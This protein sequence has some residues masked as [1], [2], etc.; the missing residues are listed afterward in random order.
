MRVAVVGATGAVGRE[1]LKVL[2]ARNFPLSELRLY[3]S[4]RS[5]GVRLAFR[6]EEIPVEPL[7]EGPLP[8]DLV[9][10]SAGGGHLQGQG[11]GLG[12]GRGLGGGQ[13]QRL[14]LRALGA[15]GGA[16]GE[17]GEDL[18]APGDHR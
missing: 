18:P 8:V 9:L 4:P 17:P 15:P 1:I 3:A 7:P 10:A 11:L 2:E 13:L 16:R 12:G 5:A 14:A 6:G